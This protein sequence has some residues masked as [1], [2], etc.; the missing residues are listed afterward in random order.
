MMVLTKYV[1]LGIITPDEA[2]SKLDMNPLG[3]QDSGKLQDRSAD[4]E[5]RV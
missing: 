3:N 1:E 2:R 5:P 4:N